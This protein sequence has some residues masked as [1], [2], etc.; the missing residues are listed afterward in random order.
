M[1][2]EGARRSNIEQYLRNVGQTTLPGME[3]D[4][5]KANTQDAIINLLG[6]KY[7]YTGSIDDLDLMFKG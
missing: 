2:A 7:G 1:Q 5:N 4:K 3:Q 6:D